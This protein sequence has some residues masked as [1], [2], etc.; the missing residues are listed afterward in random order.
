MVPVECF[1]GAR[2]LLG[3]P[4]AHLFFT[5]TYETD[6]IFILQTRKLSHREAES[7]FVQGLTAKKRLEDSFKPRLLIT[8]LSHLQS[9]HWQ[10]RNLRPREA[11]HLAQSYTA[12]Q[13]QRRKQTKHL[14][15]LRLY[16]APFRQPGAALATCFLGL[17]KGHLGSQCL[18]FS[19]HNWEKGKYRS[20]ASKGDN[21]QTA[22]TFAL[23]HYF[24]PLNPVS[25][26][27]N[28]IHMALIHLHLNL[29]N[30]R[31]V[32]YKASEPLK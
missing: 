3:V 2:H 22:C 7:Q 20:L 31:A 5:P 18:L 19:A 6:T 21:P 23:K 25:F 16:I 8:M 13:C 12:K 14:E 9:F 32:T 29:Q 11:E 28:V 17:W 1:L 26:K 10:R 27:A 24:H 30:L 4:L 15:A